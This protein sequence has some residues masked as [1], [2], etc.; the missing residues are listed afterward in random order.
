MSR[1]QTGDWRGDETAPFAYLCT[2]RTRASRGLLAEGRVNNFE[3]R[4]KGQFQG[5]P[6][7]FTRPHQGSPTVPDPQVPNVN[8]LLVKV[9]STS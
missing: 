5:H 4:Q 6:G 9:L 1:V 2:V 7:L 8:A 3:P